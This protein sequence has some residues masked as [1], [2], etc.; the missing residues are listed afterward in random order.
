MIEKKNRMSKVVHKK[1][2]TI[3]MHGQMVIYMR[4]SIWRS[5]TVKVDYYEFM[6]GT[7]KL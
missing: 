3:C 6:G 2:N 4:Q 7:R 1:V 5:T